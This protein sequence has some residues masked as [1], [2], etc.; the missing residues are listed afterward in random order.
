MPV[1]A[2]ICGI[3]HPEALRAAVDGGARYI[4]LVFFAKSPRNVS[5][6]LAAELARMVPTGV[7]TVGLFVDPTDEFL[8]QA[9]AQVPL[10]LI[11][12][13]GEETPERVAA[14]R[15]ATRLPVM[16]ALKVETAADLD[17][18]SAYE[19]VA[20]ILLFDAKPP[21]GAVL[22]GG[23]GVAFDWTLLTGRQ[24][25]KPWMLSGGLAPDTVAEAIRVSGAEA[26]DVSSGVEDRPGH[27]DPALI[28]AFLKAVRVI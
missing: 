3:N 7:R 10:D 24:W 4:G 9:L 28:R 19:P 5:L 17:A 22:P 13:H 18:A 23:N 27:K 16:K 12:L 20:D 6:P 2:K 21:K 8:D 25:A 14:I 26:V 1:K 11:Q 15:A